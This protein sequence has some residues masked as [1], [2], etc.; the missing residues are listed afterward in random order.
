MSFTTITAPVRAIR[1]IV[2]SARVLRSINPF[3]A[4]ILR[5]PLHRLLSSSML[6]L[7]FTGRKTGKQ[8]TIPVGYTREG[9]TLILFSSKSW[10]KNL[11]NDGRVAIHLQGRK[12]AG[13]AEVIEDRAAVVEAAERLVAAYG[14]KEAGRRIG[15]ALDTPPPT[16]VELAAAL[17][18]RVAIRLILEP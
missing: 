11:R 9:N 5:S 18:D 17:E 16:P 6:M 14:L 1:S 8:F 13:R 4:M 7:T 10:W 15:L 3:M 2:P 12:R